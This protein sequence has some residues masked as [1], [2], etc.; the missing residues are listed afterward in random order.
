MLFSSAPDLNPGQST[1]SCRPYF[2][3]CS[4]KAGIS[5][6]S[7]PTSVK[8]MSG[9]PQA[10]FFLYSH[11][12]SSTRSYACHQRV[13]ATP[14]M[15]MPP[16]SFLLTH[17]NSSAFMPLFILTAL[18]PKKLSAL[19]PIRT[20]ASAAFLRKSPDSLSPA[21]V[22]ITLAAFTARRLKG[23]TFFIFLI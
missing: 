22:A 21:A 18:T 4:Q 12:P 19:S 1:S 11:M 2:F 6:S 14:T 7:P 10:L 16:E 20:A 8:W 3:T 17:E 9:A 13:P 23:L 15:T 5:F